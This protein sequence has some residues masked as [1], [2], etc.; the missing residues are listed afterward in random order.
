MKLSLIS[1][2]SLLI[3]IN[4]YSQD[5]ANSRF[6][7]TALQLASVD[8]PVGAIIHVAVLRYNSEVLG[9]SPVS[10]DAQQDSTQGWML[11]ASFYFHKNKLKPEHIVEYAGSGIA[12]Q[13]N[14]HLHP[15]SNYF[16]LTYK[17]DEIG[18][19]QLLSCFKITFETIDFYLSGSTSL[20]TEEPAKF[21]KNKFI[22]SSLYQD[23]KGTCFYFGVLRHGGKEALAFSPIDTQSASIGTISFNFRLDKNKFK[24]EQVAELLT[25]YHFDIYDNKLVGKSDLKMNTEFHKSIPSYLSISPEYIRL[26]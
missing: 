4:G 23:P 15:Y 22:P 2:F 3:L 19:S 16:G 14:F 25:T 1:L 20:Q 21:I 24:V 13:K 26:K 5:L 9:I 11:A 7:P 18:P 12:I 10:I 8:K 17:V 6:K